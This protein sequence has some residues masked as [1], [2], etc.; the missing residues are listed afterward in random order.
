MNSVRVVTV[1]HSA[2]SQRWSSTDEPP[3]FIDAITGR[4]SLGTAM[5]DQ[6]PFGAEAFVVNAAQSA[7]AHAVISRLV[8]P[9][10]AITARPSARNAIEGMKPTTPVIVTSLPSV[11]HVASLHRL[12]RSSPA[13]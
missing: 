7:S 13:V 8:E 5:S 2:S 3:L 9:A 6:N 12:N 1:V 4:L 10:D 11:A